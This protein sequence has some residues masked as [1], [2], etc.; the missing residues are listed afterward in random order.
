[1]SS[2]SSSRLNERLIIGTVAAALQRLP[3]HNERQ[4]TKAHVGDGESGVNFAS[5]PFIFASGPSILA[6]GPF[7]GASIISLR[8]GMDNAPPWNLCSTHVSY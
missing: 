4:F 1:M 5:G 2:H 8:P 6:S 7:I 3:G